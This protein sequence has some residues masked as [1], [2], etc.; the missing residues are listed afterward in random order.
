VPDEQ[1]APP[2]VIELV[3]AEIASKYV[4]ELV[5]NANVLSLKIMTTVG[6]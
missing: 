1:A 4:V 5:K 6:A 2:P 3:K